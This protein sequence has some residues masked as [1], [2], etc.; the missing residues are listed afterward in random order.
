MRIIYDQG[1]IVLNRNDSR[2]AIVLKDYGDNVSVLTAD[3]NIVVNYVPKR[4]LS[5]KGHI[6]FK[7]NIKG[8]ISS[9]PK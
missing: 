3:D 5:Y 4:D 9:V 1:D 8:M 6:N 2:Y 7:Q